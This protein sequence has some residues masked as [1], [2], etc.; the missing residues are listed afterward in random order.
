MIKKV[1]PK[2]L[3]DSV[4]DILAQA[5]YH[6]SYRK[7]PVDFRG[8]L[9]DPVEAIVRS[10]G[11]PVLI[12][13]PATSCRSMSSAAFICSKTSGHPLIDTALGI[14]NGRIANYAGSPLQKYHE[15]FQPA[16]LADFMG[17]VPAD[18][19]PV[20][21]LSPYAF[22]YPWEGIPNTQMQRQNYQWMVTENKKHR[23]EFSVMKEWYAIGPVSME[24]GNLEFERLSKVLYSVKEKG[25]R[26]V[27][28]LDGDICGVILVKDGKFV[29][30][31]SPGQHRIAVLVALGCDHVP[32]RIGNR[33]VPIVH[34]ETVKSWPAVT[35]GF[36]N[37]LQALNVFDRVFEGRQPHIY[38]NKNCTASCENMLLC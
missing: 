31:I 22:V 21:L 15:S 10:A 36:F 18:Q 1:F 37:E 19:H 16:N 35:G 13:L 26:R 9:D 24:K 29:A 8:L 34:R 12:E 2:I 27:D 33:A 25:F 7:P 17:I 30:L 32:V 11:N 6:R 3:K 20:A 5:G 23:P 28:G 38:S 4:I 14:L